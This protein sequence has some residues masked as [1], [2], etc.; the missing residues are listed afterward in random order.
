MNM[1]AIVTSSSA[2]GSNMM[3]SP[4]ADLPWGVFGENLTIEGLLEGE[5]RPGDRL[6]IGSAEFEIT[7]PRLPCFKLGIRF[8]DDLMVRR[9]AQSGRSGFYLSV[10]K[11]GT[12]A[13]GDAIMFDPRAEDDVTIAD[14]FMNH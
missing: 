2:R 8:G 10:I 3:A 7:T 13:A 9:F 11:V 5:V 14:M 1:S 6:R 4:A 12:L